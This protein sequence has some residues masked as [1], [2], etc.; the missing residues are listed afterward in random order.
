MPVSQYPVRFYGSVT[1][2]KNADGTVSK[3]WVGGEVIQAVAY[4]NPIPGFDTYNTINLRLWRAA[5]SHE[6]N[7]K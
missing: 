3:K 5:P 7:L 2:T 4:D 6:F 1:S